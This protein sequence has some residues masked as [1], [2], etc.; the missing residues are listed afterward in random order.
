MEDD[1]IVK[2]YFERNETAILET[3][4][5][6]GPYCTAIAYRILQN[7]SDAEECVADTWLRAWNAM[8]PQ[9]PRVLRQFLAKIT[10]NLSL[11]RWRAARMEKRG[12][13]EITVALEELGECIVGETDPATQ[14]ELEELKKS[15]AAFLRT[16]PERER[17]IFLR[18]Y[19][20]LETMETIAKHHGLQNAN[21]R[22][23][24]SRTRLKLKEFL[25]K[26]GL[27]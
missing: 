26:E 1:Q 8:P 24:L 4:Q 15:I 23:I 14:L 7:S 18:R 6:Y 19:F 21:V 25:R 12:G 10:R 27:M 11:D 3:N 20:Y 13:G 2:L 22:L 16:L 9:K 17:S 5:K